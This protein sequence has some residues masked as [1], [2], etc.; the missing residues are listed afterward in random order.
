MSLFL[1]FPALHHHHHYHMGAGGARDQVPIPGLPCPGGGGGTR[2]QV[3][4]PWAPLG[5]SPTPARKHTKTSQ[6]WY[7]VLVH[8]DTPPNIGFRGGGAGPGARYRSPWLLWAPPTLVMTMVNDDDGDDDDG[9][10]DDDHAGD[11][12]VMM[13]VMKLVMMKIAICF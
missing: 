6:F 11:D 9:D 7:D 5:P 10:D 1:N 8:N 13:L 2:G 3:P 4:I 12:L